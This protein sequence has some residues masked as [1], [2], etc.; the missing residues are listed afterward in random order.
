MP[1]P[2]ASWI[3]TLLFAVACDSPPASPDNADTPKATP[4][5]PGQPGAETPGTPVALPGP[6]DPPPPL[7]EVPPPEPPAKDGEPGKAPP[8]QVPASNGRTP[9]IATTHPMYARFEG[10]SMNNACTSDSACAKGGCSGEV[11]SADKDV[12][13]TCEVIEGL[14]AGAQC[15]CVS[16]TCV[17]YTAD[18]GKPRPG[19]LATKEK[20]A[21][22]NPATPGVRCGKKT[23]AAGEQCIE[24][25]GIAGPKGPKLRT[26]GVPCKLGKKGQCPAGKRCVMISDGAGAVCQ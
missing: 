16:N 10:T 15:G 17:W 26:C 13:T 21:G 2:R 25:Y 1:S 4:A 6:T 20:T 12:T 11:C 3:C 9:A 24:Y 8:E 23:C 7:D 5:A 18:A 19:K 22:K 14:P